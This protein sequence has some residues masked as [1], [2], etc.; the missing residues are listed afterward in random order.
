MSNLY[1]WFVWLHVLA[2]FVFFFSHGAEMATAFML[3]KVKDA[4]GMK[5]LLNISQITHIPF[6]AFGVSM[7]LLL[8]TSV[9]MG[10]TAGWW[11]R[12]WWGLSFLIMVGM[13]V[14]MSWYARKYYSPIRK[15][16]GLEYMTGFS[17]RNPAETPESMDIVY[18]LVARTN[19]R[20]LAWVGLIFTATLLFLMRFKPF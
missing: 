8:I 6:G 2:A 9:Y 12:G 5:A 7:L 20:L 18:A 17:T 10:V 14:W 19:P 15:A 16:L 3:P 13:T 4:N 1:Q 11:R